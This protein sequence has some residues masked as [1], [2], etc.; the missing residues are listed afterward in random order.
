MNTFV[1]HGKQVLAEML[2]QPLEKGRQIKSVLDKVGELEAL[3]GEINDALEELKNDPSVVEAMS[4]RKELKEMVPGEGPLHEQYNLFAGGSLEV[5]RLLL[6]DELAK[7]A[8]YE[9]MRDIKD[10]INQLKSLGK[11]QV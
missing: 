3:L 5:T 2:E 11:E 1:L 8:G 10:Q 4:L 7:Y 9:S 6:P